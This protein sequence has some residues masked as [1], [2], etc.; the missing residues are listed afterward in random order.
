MTR[1]LVLLVATLFIIGF[2]FLT[3]HTIVAQKGI[4][5]D[6]AASVFVVVLMGV[7]IIGA[8]LNPPRR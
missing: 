2:A 7:G 1:L 5:I 6:S 8:L 3:L 4:S